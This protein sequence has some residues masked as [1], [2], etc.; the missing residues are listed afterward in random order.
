MH[1][2]AI[3]HHK[4]D[5][6]SSHCKPSKWTHLNNSDIDCPWCQF[7]KIAMT[8]IQVLPLGENF[9]QSKNIYLHFISKMIQTIRHGFILSISCR[10]KR[11]FGP[12][13]EITMQSQKM[14]NFLELTQNQFFDFKKNFVQQNFHFKFLGLTISWTWFRNA[15]QWCHITSWLGIFND[16]GTLTSD[17][18]HITNYV[19]S[20]AR[21]IQSKHMGAEPTLV[22]FFS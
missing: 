1:R 20:L 16:L 18:Y 9:P 6:I 14:R 10:E 2:A 5:T 22:Q 13:L 3:I 15:N 21:G 17:R 4:K 19:A 12:A 11:S 7:S 8:C